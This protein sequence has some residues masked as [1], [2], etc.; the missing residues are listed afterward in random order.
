MAD[1]KVGRMTLGSFQTNCYYVYRESAKNAAESSSK[2]EATEAV[3]CP[4]IVVD[5]AQQGEAIYEAL[6]LKGFFV[7]AILLTHGHVDHIAGVTE[8]KKCSGAKV[9]ACE[10]EA[11]L[12][13]DMQDNLSIMFGNP[14]KVQ[15]DVL[16]RDGEETTLADMS[17]QTIATPGHTIGSC[18]YYFKE[19]DILLSGDTLFDGSVGRT[20]FPTGSM[21]LL[22][23]SIKNKLFV[24]PEKTICYPGH[25]GTT[26]IGWEK[27]NNPFVV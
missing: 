22:V 10:K 15:A 24:L 18:A 9:Y 26:T 7:A 6:K 20:D 25:G 1:L 19:A 13:T 27:D 4:A 2:G 21:S 23:R 8:L 14:L 5:P 17:F 12:L 11:E 16:L 3:L